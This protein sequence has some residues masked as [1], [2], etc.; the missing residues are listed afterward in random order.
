MLVLRPSA[1]NS[2]SC[3][4]RS[5]SH[6]CGHHSRIRRTVFRVP[7]CRAG[8]IC[9]ARAGQPWQPRR[10]CPAA[11]G[12]AG[13]RAGRRCPGQRETTFPFFRKP[14]RDPRHCVGWV[15]R[16]SLQSF[17]RPILSYNANDPDEIA[18]LQ[19]TSGSTRIPRGVIITERALM[20]NLR[21]IVRNGLR[22]TQGRS[23]R[24]LAA[25]LS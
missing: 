5:R 20:S 15:P 11:S 7:L 24:V 19:F 16:S 8:S 21:G 9:D 22:D 2:R 17:P 6:H 14:P 10:V 12:N 25:L 3:Q 4:R 1:G 23:L 18:Y 13:R